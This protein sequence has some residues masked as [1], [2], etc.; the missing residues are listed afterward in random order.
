MIMLKIK[1]NRK[2]TEEEEEVRQ[3]EKRGRME[4]GKGEKIMLGEKIRDVWKEKVDKVI[5]GEEK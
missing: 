5:K 4:E 1:I 3:E 2:K